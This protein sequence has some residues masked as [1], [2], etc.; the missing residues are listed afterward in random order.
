MCAL[1]ASTVISYLTNL[2]PIRPV[3]VVYPIRQIT[4]LVPILSVLVVYPCHHC[5][6]HKK[7][8][9][10]PILMVYLVSIQQSTIWVPILLFMVVYPVITALSG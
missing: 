2:V 3:H 4:T 8:T 6:V 9:W 10:V 1:R 5:P 7:K